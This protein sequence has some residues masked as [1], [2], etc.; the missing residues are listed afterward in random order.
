MLEYTVYDPL[1]GLILRYGDCAEHDWKNQAGP[2]EALWPYYEALRDDEWM[3]VNGEK[4][5][6]EDQ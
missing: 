1:T 2:G 5:P 4:V 3:I 6:H